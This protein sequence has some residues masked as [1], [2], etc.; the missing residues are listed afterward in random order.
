MK[1]GGNRAR[2]RPGWPLQ[3]YFAAVGVLVVLAGVAAGAYVYIQPAYYASQA[4]IGASGQ[5]RERELAIIV[6]GVLLTLLAL[7]FVYRQVASPMKSLGEAVRASRDSGAAV[8][9]AGPVQVAAL[10]E[11]IN[12]LITSLKQLGSERENARRS[13]ADLFEG[14]PL[15]ILALDTTT[16]RIIDVNEAAVKALG[17]SREEFKKLKTSEIVIPETTA[18][19]ARIRATRTANAPTLR[20]GP[21]SYL[22][23]DGSFMRA[24]GTSYVVDYGDQKLRIA[25]LEDVTQKEKIERQMEQV[26]R[27]ESLG[28]LAG[29]VAHDFNNLLTV[30]LNVTDSLKGAVTD[31]EARRDIDRVNTAAQCAS[32][33]TRQ[34]LAFARR[35]VMPRGVVNVDVQLTELKDLLSRTLGSHIIFTLELAPDLWPVLMDRGQLE[36]IVINLSVNAR[37]AMPNGGKL[38]IGT[39]NVTIDDI[40]AQAR[41][42]LEPGR[43]VRVQISDSG[44]GMDKATLDHAFEPFFTTKP[45][46]RGT[47]MGL[48]TVYGIV[49]QLMGHVSISSEVGHGTTVTVLIPATKQVPEVEAPAALVEH[50]S[51]SGTVLVVE[52]Y[53]DLRELFQEILT[54]AG[55]EVMA[56]GDGAEA[57]ALARAHSGT[58]DVVLTDVVMPNMLGTDLAAQLRSENPGIRVLFMSGHAQPVVGAGAA[59]PPGAVLLQKP[60]MEQELLDKLQAVLAAPTPGEAAGLFPA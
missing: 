53:H 54:A 22:K 10:G 27:L 17:Y 57:L 42:G 21:L 15:P 29:G 18:E 3:R 39:D 5:L 47:G 59:L 41:P 4:A 52:D 31:Q 19:A 7:V 11:D 34:L 26:Q 35:E 36:Q 51:A 56:A 16:L 6:F 50:R 55:Y 49:K 43:Y 13:Y 25:M 24:T 30:I 23:R 9:I 14:N 46:G 45:V 44:T 48:A 12:E 33:L 40:Y 37:D 32:R 58:I 60:F 8:P 28:Q 38:V 1:T 20:F 2:Q